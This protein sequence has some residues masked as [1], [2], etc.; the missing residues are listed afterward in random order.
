MPASRSVSK[1]TIESV[2]SFSTTSRAGPAG[3]LRPPSGP[4]TT[5][6]SPGNRPRPPVIAEFCGAHDHA[7]NRPMPKVTTPTASKSAAR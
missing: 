1:A 7:C 5:R 2:R 4:A 6:R 3:A